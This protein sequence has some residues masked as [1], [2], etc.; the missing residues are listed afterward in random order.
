[1]RLNEQTLLEGHKVVLVPY[2]KYHVPRYHEWMKSPELQQLTA[3]EPLTMD[4]EYEMQKSWHLDDNKLTFI[5]LDKVKW[6][7]PDISEEDSMCGDV[8]LFFNDA[9][10]SSVAEIE[11]MIAEPSC[12]GKGFGKEVL[13]L[14]MQYGISK[15]SVSKYVAKIGMENQVSIKMFTKLGFS[16]VSISEV[17]QE[18]TLDY[19]ITDEV[20]GQLA[21]QTSHMITQQYAKTIGDVC[22]GSED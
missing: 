16:Q 20:K 3:S 12:R 2:K 17:F 5:V 11:I 8:N 1:M 13:L 18:V 14:M 6:Q 9:D 22:H 15:L 10:D 19:S 4:Q 21:Q 7:D